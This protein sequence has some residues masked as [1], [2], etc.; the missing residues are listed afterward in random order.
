MQPTGSDGERC[1]LRIHRN[2]AP[3]SA[4]IPVDSR[5]SRVAGT[6]AWQL[7]SGTEKLPQLC[8]GAK[9]FKSRH[10]CL[11]NGESGETQTLQNGRLSMPCWCGL[12][13]VLVER[14]HVQGHYLPALLFSR[15][16]L[17]DSLQPH[18]LQHARPPCPSPA[19]S[20][21]SDSRPSSR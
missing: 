12:H 1:S 18:G 17:S 4:I 20:V 11:H 19:P 21:C 10:A 16:V 14:N 15:S 7:P 6:W 3:S 2:T 9:F 8:P 13:P 5:E